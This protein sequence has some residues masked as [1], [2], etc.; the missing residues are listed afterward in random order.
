MA[1]IDKD[2]LPLSEDAIPM[3]HSL[4]D[5]SVISTL[6][7]Q[8]AIIYKICIVGDKYIEMARDF[9]ETPNGSTDVLYTIMIYEEDTAYEEDIAHMT[10][11]ANRRIF[12][13]RE[14]EIINIFDACSKRVIQQEMQLLKNRIVRLTSEYTYN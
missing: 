6:H 12:T 1:T 11:S 3:I 10:V 7:E 8:G 14:Q 4:I 9:F 13:P 5:S 2:F